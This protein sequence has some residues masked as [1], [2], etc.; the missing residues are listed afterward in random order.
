[1]NTAPLASPPAT[2]PTAGVRMISAS[3]AASAA[4]AAASP[5]RLPPLLSR[6]HSHFLIPSSS[7]PRSSP[8]PLPPLCEARLGAHG[9]VSACASASV[10][11]PASSDAKTI[12]WA[13]LAVLGAGVAGLSAA[14]RAAARGLDVVVVT[15]GR[16]GPGSGC[17]PLAQGGVS[18]V[19]DPADSWQAH[20]ADTLAAGDGLGDLAAVEAVCREGPARV[21]ELA[22]LGAAFDPADTAD[23]AFSRVADI[24][25][26][27]L[28]PF[29]L[30]LEGGHSA[31]RVVHAADA[32]GAEVHRALVAAARAHPL[33]RVVE[34]HVAVDLVVAE[35]PAFHRASPPLRR[36]VGVDLL[37]EEDEERQ[38]ESAPSS[39]PRAVRLLAPATLLA[40]GGA[41]QAWPQT[42]NPP[43]V[44]GDG[45]AIA[46]R[47]G[48]SV[49]NLEFV[50]FHP[51]A[52]YAGP[53]A[54]CWAPPG[55][56]AGLVGADA[57]DVADGSEAT[58][59][60]SLGKVP[61]APP[62]RCLLVTEAV[63]G[64]GG[65]LLDHTGRRFLAD[66]PGAELAPRD[67][68]ARGIHAEMIRSGAP[69]VWLDVSHRGVAHVERHFPTVRR[70]ILR[71]TGRD[72][73]RGPVPVCPAQHYL[74]GG[75]AT[76][77]DA[78]TTLAGLLACG[79]VAHTGLHGANRLASNSLLEGLVFGERAAATAA[80]LCRGEGEC[81][82]D[83]RDGSNEH[84][85]AHAVAR[86]ATAAAAAEFV[87]T[88]AWDGLP[89]DSEGASATAPA[90][91]RAR[92]R[93]ALWK[94][95]G[96]LRDGPGL[97]IARREAEAA[98]SAA[99]DHLKARAPTRASLEARNVATVAALVAAAAEARTES[100]GGH[101]RS[102]FPASRRLAYYTFAE[103]T[104]DPVRA[105]RVEAAAEAVVEMAS[106]A[107]VP[108][109]GGRGLR[110]RLSSRPTV[111]AR[112]TA[113]ARE[114]EGPRTE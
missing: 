114:V 32:T 90:A 104:D 30:A 93:A 34:G 95:A 79:E 20:A 107:A 57:L 53:D 86:R 77:L 31:R 28:S 113:E 98:L 16:L 112:A 26:G 111:S 43:D 62:G 36:C 15:K 22:A 52:L 71:A 63:R 60:T 92:A 84:P 50:Q 76:D 41:G 25:D 64:E 35:G 97:A 18:A 7:S 105:V 85:E 83:G 101:H 1:M 4:P 103:A 44:T 75:V 33:V 65:V 110:R 54:A 37:T 6:P 72:L 38:G 59:T 89:T 10:S 70:A 5:R 56:D 66:A 68:V 13:D 29:D 12:L 42:T 88:P 11:V 94:G 69:C 40:T 61:P 14:L 17:T 78:R 81:E 73:A 99:R 102:D 106:E 87:A 55:A 109:R 47:A 91:A 67:A 48:A 23:G 24:A 46:H 58:T 80:R 39:P 96:V 74:C 100:R 82:N 51:T 2:A 19:F 3:V 9:V 108:E 21:L 8:L 49:A 45:L 27:L